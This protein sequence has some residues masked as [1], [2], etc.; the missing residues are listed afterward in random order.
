MEL[1]PELIKTFLYKTDSQFPVPLSHKQDLSQFANKLY[2]QATLCVETN[3]LEIIAMVAGYT[4]NLIDNIAYISVVATL[5][6]YQGNGYASKLINKFIGFCKE[7]SIDAVHL[8][9]DSSNNIAIKMYKQ[10]GF[11]EWVVPNESRPKDKHLIYYIKSEL[12]Q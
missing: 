2:N 6:E 11:T 12:K 4:D 9:T 7:K 1:T 3:E 8:Y 10:L 5:C